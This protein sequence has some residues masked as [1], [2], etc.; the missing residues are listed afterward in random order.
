MIQ[1]TEGKKIGEILLEAGLVTEPQMQEALERQKQEGGRICSHLIKLGY[2]KADVLLEFLRL[3]FGVAAV[4][5]SSYRIPDKVLS[6]IPAPL[7]RRFHVIPVNVLEQSLTLAMED[8]RDSAAIEAVE[9]Q[10]T[11]KVDPLIVPQ[12]VLEEALQKY[13]PEE[14]EY[15][16]QG[17]ERKVFALDEK[18]DHPAVYDPK[19]TP[20]NLSPAN[21]LKRVIF[22]GIKKRSREI[23]LEPREE[24]TL[25]R[26]RTGAKLV[27]GDIIP[28]TTSLSMISLLLGFSGHDPLGSARRPIEGWLR[29]RVKNREL[30]LLFSTFPVIHGDRVVMRLIDESYLKRPLTEQGLDKAEEARVARALRGKRGLF[31][32]SSPAG[33]QRNWTMY[34]LLD[35]LKNDNVNIVTVEP[36]LLYPLPGVNQTLYS[37]RKGRRQQDVLEG[38]LRQEPDIIGLSE[39]DDYV[40]LEKALTAASQ[41]LVLGTLPMVNTYE[42]ITW[43][44]GARYNSLAMAHLL[45]GMFTLRVIPRLCPACRRPF[46]GRIDILE[47]TRDKRP[48]DMRFYEALGCERCEGTGR[49]GHLGLFESVVLDDELRDLFALG[50]PAKVIYEEAQRRGMMTLLE[51]G[52]IKASRGEVDVRDVLRVASAV[53]E[54]TP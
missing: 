45:V 5:L 16:P 17:Q 36:Y 31:L 20:G 24:D 25:V 12:A 37:L 19:E 18:T 1:S 10:T 51:D 52:F 13:Y 34:H 33:Q 32:V 29:L 7:A 3:Q 43:L 6:L 22:L 46:E 21:W 15:R 30:K 9:R 41:C 54:R 35:L 48:E 44:Q 11:L 53:V 14:K 42:V 4:N 2:L 28:R 8:P 50:A 23:H 26:Y 49:I 40:M 27:N 38:A 39:M 47:G